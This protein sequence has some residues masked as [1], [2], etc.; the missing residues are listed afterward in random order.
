MGESWEWHWARMVRR[1]VRRVKSE[2]QRAHKQSHLSLGLGAG[3]GV[4]SCLNPAS[5]ERAMR[6][7]PP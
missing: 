6:C 2:P 7:S 4:V 1:R 3:A 5:P